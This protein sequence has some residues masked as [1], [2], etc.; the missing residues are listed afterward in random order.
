MRSNQL[1]I[2]EFFDT[3]ITQRTQDSFFNATEL[4]K[5][6]NKKT[7]QDRRFRDFWKNK[8]TIEFCDVLKN[9]L[10][11]NRENSTHLIRSPLR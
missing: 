6:Y 2:R 11:G 8:N 5:F 9:E 7:D 3:Q 1:M 10:L 4:L